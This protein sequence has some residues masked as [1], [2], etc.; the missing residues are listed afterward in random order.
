MAQPVEELGEIQVEVPQEGVHADH[1]GQR[2]A[3]VA[4][5][6]LHPGFQRRRLEVAQ[7][8][9]QGLPGLQVLVGHGADRNQIQVPGQQH[10]G[11]ALEVPGQ[12]ALEAA[13]HFAL[14]VAR[15][16][17]PDTEI[18]ELE[19][20]PFGPLLLEAPEQRDLVV[21]AFAPLGQRG[22]RI[23]TAE[24]QLVDQR[25]HEDLEGHGVDLRPACLDLQHRPLHGGGNEVALEAEDAQE[26]DEV[27]LDVAQRA[28]VVQLVGLESQAAQVV[29]LLVDLA[30][31]LGQRIVGLVA[32]D[33]G[34]FGLGLRMPM[35][36]GLPHGELVEV[37]VQ[38]ALDDGLHGCLS[39]RRGLVHVGAGGPFHSARA[40]R[41]T[42]CR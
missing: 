11:G 34:V 7:P 27:A 3:Q 26:V 28:H 41:R 4:A 32:A 36:H 9:R 40:H 5:V 15:K 6:F 35:Q 13:D 18:E 38:Q 42:A 25:Q 24:I 29:Q 1:V 12:L 37:G 10:V 16:A 17:P 19:G 14:P 22:L 2:N 23:E 31:Q 21:Q 20:M 33:E 8:H 39:E 30:E